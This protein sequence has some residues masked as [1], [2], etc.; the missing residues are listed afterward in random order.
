MSPGVGPAA[1]CQRYGF[2][3]DF[4]ERGGYDALN[5]RR[6]PLRLPATIGCSVKSNGNADV[7]PAGRRFSFKFQIPAPVLYKYSNL[8]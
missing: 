7:A 2:A 6:V 8:T 1:A 4:G 3:C 5:G